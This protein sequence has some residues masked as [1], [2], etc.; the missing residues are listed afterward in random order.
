MASRN[1]GAAL[2]AT[3]FAW[4]VALLATSMAVAAPGALA[5]GA[6][7]APRAPVAGYA[8]FS[9]LGGASVPAVAPAA[10]T[11]TTTKVSESVATVDYG[12]ESAAVF[13]VEVTG[14]STEGETAEVRVGGGSG[15]TVHLAAGSGKCT[16]ANAAL[17]AS[18]GSYAV[19]ASYPGD[20]SLEASEGT[21]KGGLT[22]TGGRSFTKVA[23]SAG[24][25][26]YGAESSVEFEAEVT[27]EGGAA[28]PSGETV[29]IKVGSATCMADLS[30]GA[31]S[32]GKCSVSSNTVLAPGASYAVSAEY[33]GDGNLSGSKSANSVSLLVERKST[34]FKIKVEGSESAAT[35]TVGAAATVTE[36][37]LPSEAQGTVTVVSGKTSLCHFSVPAASS[38][39]TAK[40]LEPGKYS[41]VTATFEETGGNYASSV[42]TNRPSLL[43]ERKN[44]SFQIKLEGSESGATITV[45]SAAT[46]SETGLPSE[47]Q[48]TVTV[49]SGK[50]SLCHFSVPAAKL[51]CDIKSTRTG[52]LPGS[53]GDL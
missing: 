10:R 17:S 20:E 27:A 5:P 28:L 1:I 35:I 23:E 37:G 16:I 33:E 2:A 6:P 48:G 4:V 22:V 36:T 47:A 19:A 25:V 8:A 39:A 43:V 46:I 42:S 14:G 11:A 15:C 45:G 32:T 21:V 53:H 9:Q 29:A 40:T 34:S 24:T 12:D 52:S 13:T 26:T 38:C 31:K 30:G 18:A 41:E 44:T 51:V 50:T 49:V 7:L 3:V